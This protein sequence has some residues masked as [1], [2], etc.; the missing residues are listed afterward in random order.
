MRLHFPPRWNRPRWIALALLAALALP[1]ANATPQLHAGAGAIGG[2]GTGDIGAGCTTYGAPASVQ[3][4]FGSGYGLA[5]PGGGVAACG[6]S[7][8][9][10][11][12]L[13]AS[14][15][16]ASTASV[17]PVILGNPG[18]AGF[19]TGSADASAQFTALRAGARGAY[20][21]GLPGGQTALSDAS[22]AAWF[23]DNLTLSSPLVVPFSAGFVGYRFEFSGSLAATGTPM[24]Y[25]FGEALAQLAFQH[26]G[27]PIYGIA[28][29]YTRRGELGTATSVGHPLPGWTGAVG[30]V[31]GGGFVDT[32]DILLPFPIVFGQPW[33]LTLGLAAR[34]YGESAAEFLST[35]RFVGLDVFDAQGNRITDFTLTSASGTDYLAPVPEPASAVLLL[36]G[37]GLAGAM[38]RRKRDRDQH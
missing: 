10:T 23:T 31:S 19:Y 11:Q 27:G 7:G 14:G 5:L 16:A 24:P 35:A 34:A 37:I 3:A 32:L 2:L 13:V 4:F 1:T 36:A 38:V 29:A 28:Q 6:Y 25:Y 8:G 20:S 22:G 26:E 12:Q 21:A 15:T 9:W 17:G 30:S 33:E 18:F